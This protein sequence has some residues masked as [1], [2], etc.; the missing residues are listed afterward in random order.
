MGMI[1]VFRKG[2]LQ[3]GTFRPLR[4]AGLLRHLS[5]DRPPDGW[6]RWSRLRRLF[7]PLRLFLGFSDLPDRPID[8]RDHQHGGRDNCSQNAC[9]FFRVHLDRPGLPLTG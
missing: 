8:D 6:R 2:A 5:D 3:G 1:G 9:Y 4:A 7:S